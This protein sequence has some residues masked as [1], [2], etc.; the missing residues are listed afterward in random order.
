MKIDSSSI[1]MISRKGQGFEWKSSGCAKCTRKP[2]PK[3]PCN[4]NLSPIHFTFVDLRMHFL[5][6]GN[7]TLKSYVTNVTYTHSRTL[8]HKHIFALIIIS[9]N[10]L[11]HYLRFVN[12]YHFNFDTCTHTNRFTD[13]DN[14]FLHKYSTTVYVLKYYLIFLEIKTYHIRW[15][16]MSRQIFHIFMCFINDFGQFFPFNHFLK[17]IHCNAI[18]EIGQ[19]GRIF[20]DNLCDSWTP[21]MRNNNLHN[22]K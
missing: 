1:F 3:Q 8:V 4:L 18:I 10:Q 2:H 19:F 13:Y 21:E 12:F 6:L 7:C 5:H 16:L 9:V 17:H 22:M 15:Q 11:S 14:N 20:T